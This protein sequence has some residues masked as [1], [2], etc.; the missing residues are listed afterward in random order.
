[1]DERARNK[2]KLREVEQ[3]DGED[4]DDEDDDH[5]SYV[6]M[7]GVEAEK[8]LEGLKKAPESNKKQKNRVKTG[9]K[10]GRVRG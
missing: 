4:E 10:R 2:R 8:P 1:M 3:E 5:D 9:R 6:A 7:D